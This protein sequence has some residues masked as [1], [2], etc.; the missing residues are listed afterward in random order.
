MNRKDYIDD[1]WEE[2]E[3]DS[4]EESVDNLKGPFDP[5]NIDVD[6]STVNLGSMLEQLE[7][8]EIDLQPEF[9]RASGVWT[10]VKKSRLIESV[11]LGLPLPSFYFSEDA[12]T[13]KLIIIDGLQRLCSLKE[14]CIDKTLVLNNLQFLTNLNGVSYD[15]LDR[16]QVRRL[17]SLKI[18]INTLRKRTPTNVKYVIFQR[19]NTAGEPLN[20]QEVRNALYQGKATRLLKSMAAL[21]SFRIVTRKKVPTK[22]MADRDLVN[23]YLAFYLKKD[24]Y[25]GNLDQF[26]GE[27]TLGYINTLDD[28]Q[29]QNI[30]NTF[31]ST[32]DICW[33]LF[34]DKAF[35]RPNPKIEGKY[36]KLNK[37]IFEVI[38][39]SLALLTND[40]QSTLIKKKKSFISELDK[41]LRDE[42]FIQSITSGTAKVPQVE[43]RFNKIDLLIKTVL[44]Q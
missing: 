30:L 12:T 34:G 38:S 11:L 26:M 40:E 2:R 31:K 13:N 9:Q 41:L 42:H 29:V 18:T 25:D 35:R 37:S 23:R 8:G 27:V 7:Y 36:L 20:P 3:V 44:E 19:V 16:T 4:Q 17:K 5:N 43:Y 21:E 32:M 14:F 10:D 28:K 22:R 6:I 24:V 1:S 15:E 33:E 39:V